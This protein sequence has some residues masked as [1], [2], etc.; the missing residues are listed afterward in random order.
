MNANTVL[1]VELY[2]SS[3]REAVFGFDIKS[4]PLLIKR[5]VC[6]KKFHQS[7]FMYRCFHILNTILPQNAW[8]PVKKFFPGER[9]TVV[10]LYL[11]KNNLK[12][13]QIRWNQDD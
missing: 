12:T 9:E 7:Y 2:I 13:K 1:L 5:H 11:K 10:V 4:P 8:N 3:N 6:R